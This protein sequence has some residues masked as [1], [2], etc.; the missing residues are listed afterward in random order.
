MISATELKNGTT[1]VMDSNPYR[2]VKYTHQK[3]GRGGATVRLSVR[4]LRTGAHEDKT[5]NSTAKVDEISTQKRSLQYLYSDGSTA[6][7]MDP[8]SFEQ[9]EIPRSL[10]ENEL[11]YI[12]EG[13]NVDVLFWDEKPL[14]VDIPLKVNLTVVDAPPGVKGDTAS[15]MYKTAKLENSLQVRVPLFIKTGDRVR[16][17]TRTGEYVERAK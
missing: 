7:F 1:F 5:L 17:D 11:I 13:E 12:K 6:S 3:I 15:N 14:S 9:I 4:N 16:V 2:V 10:I 8:V